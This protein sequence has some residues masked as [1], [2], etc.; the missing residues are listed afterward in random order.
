V[1]LVTALPTQGKAG[2]I[3]T[4]EEEVASLTDRILAIRDG[5]AAE[6]WVMEG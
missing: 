3:I 2:I 4:H 1:T 6:E 5:L